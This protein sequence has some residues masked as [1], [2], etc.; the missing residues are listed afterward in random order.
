MSNSPYVPKEWTALSP[1]KEAQ[2]D[3]YIEHFFPRRFARCS[4][5]SEPASPCKFATLFG[6]PK[7]ESGVI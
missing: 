7:R 4:C 3:A 6:E 1:E 5:H 2:I